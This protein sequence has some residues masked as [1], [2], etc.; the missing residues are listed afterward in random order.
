MTRRKWL[1]LAAAGGGCGRSLR[2]EPPLTVEG[3]FRRGGLADAPLDSAPEPLRR[4]GVRRVQRALYEGPARIEATFY[5]MP[6]GASAFEALQKWKPAEGSM[7][8]HEGEWFVVAEAEEGG[9]AQ[10]SAFLN[11]LRKVL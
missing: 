3:G 1:F 11:G 2:R 9:P 7:A 5:E 4:L 6:T 8:L 10:L